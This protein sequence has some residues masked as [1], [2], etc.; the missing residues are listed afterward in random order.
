M[1]N[2][3]CEDLHSRQRGYEAMAS[4][5][6]IP[7]EEYL[8]TEYEPDAEYVDGEIEERPMGQFDH[9][10]WQRAIQ[11]WFLLREEEWNILVLPEQRVQVSLTRY[12]VPD[13]LL[14][15]RNEPKEQILTR[16]PI[17]VFEVLSPEDRVPRIVIKLQ[18]YER[19]GIQNIFLVDPRDRP[20]WQFRRGELV[21][22]VSGPIEGSPC[23]VDWEQIRKYVG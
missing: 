14:F 8:H 10:S 16:P 13:V 17:A 19:M 20:A 6:Q 22:A 3:C 18:D 2:L 1:T 21:E 11:K 12:R 23:I 5:A 4:I 9:S 15:D 7:V